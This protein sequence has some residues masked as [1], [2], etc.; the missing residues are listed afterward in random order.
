M[1]GVKTAVLLAALSALLLIGGEAW[2]GRQGLYLGLGIA[3]LM[4]FVGYFFSDKI[5][6]TMYSAKLVTETENGEVGS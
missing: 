4:N 6:L 1:N 3:F 5:A 2:G